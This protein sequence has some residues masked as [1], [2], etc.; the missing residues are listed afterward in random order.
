MLIPSTIKQTLYQYYYGELFRRG[1]LC[2]RVLTANRHVVV[3]NGY[4]SE[5]GDFLVSFLINYC[6]TEDS[7]ITKTL[8]GST[9]TI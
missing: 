9:N 4:N 2:W 8:Q 6:R 7:H 5:T 3:M 1:F